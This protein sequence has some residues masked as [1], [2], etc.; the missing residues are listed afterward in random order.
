[1]LQIRASLFALFTVLPSV[2][3]AQTVATHSGSSSVNDRV[4]KAPY[5]ARRRF[6]NVKK[7]GDGTIDRTETGGS[8]A[9]DSAGCTY[10]AG[11][12]L[13]TYWD[14]KK[15]VLKSEM[16][17]R[18]SDPVAKTDTRWD[19][20]SNEV[21]VIH[22]PES[23][24]EELASKTQC[25]TACYEDTMSAAGTVIEKLGT[26]T[27]G[28][29]SADGTR[30]SYTVPAGQDHNNQPIVI[31]HERWYCEELRVVILETNDD[32]R[33]GTSTDELVDILR[34]EPDVT[35]YLPPADYIVHD[36]K[37]P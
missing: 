36:I 19:S 18:I 14:G 20:S 7:S 33:S 16:L 34:S 24:P 22:W 25:A 23:A 12:R 30:T 27:L 31:V 21:K 29:V 17:Y 11:E 13:W 1:M 9:R 28:A 3:L 5:S 37:L 26:K 6:T 8:E 15:R 10:S 2:A 35:K 32:P 4:L